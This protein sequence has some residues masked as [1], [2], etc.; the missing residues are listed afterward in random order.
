MYGII[1]SEINW[2]SS[3][4]KNHKQMAY[5]QQDCSIF[6]EVHSWV[7]QGSVL[8]P[9][10]FSLPINDI[11]NFTKEGCILNM[12]AD[13]VIIYTSAPSRD[14]LQ[15]KLQLYIDNVHNWYYM[16]RLIINKK[17]SAVMVIG[18]KA[19]LQYLNLD[20][21]SV[22]L[23]SNK[24]EL[25]S[26]VKYLGLFVND[27][28]S[29]DEHILQL[30]KSMNYYVHVIRRLNKLFPEHLLLRLYKSYVQSKLDIDS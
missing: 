30:C 3:Y 18:S 1:G 26:K 25:V 8:G 9:L 17:K 13:D 22:Y 29:W 19:Q 20:Q 24:I 7:P 14:E 21:F 5:F 4:L 15:R 28:L 6:Q 16:N 23:D 11:Y 10:L 2:F 12:F 27:D